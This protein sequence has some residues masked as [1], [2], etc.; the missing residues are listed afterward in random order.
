[1]DMTPLIQDDSLD[2]VA[3]VLGF[4]DKFR[5]DVRANLSRQLGRN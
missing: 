4:I 5:E 2:V 1:M 3:Y